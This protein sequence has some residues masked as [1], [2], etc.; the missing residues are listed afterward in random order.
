M[1]SLTEINTSNSAL[2]TED[3]YQSFISYLD[4]SKKTIDTYSRALKQ[5]FRYLSSKSIQQPNR[6][7]IIAFREELK[8]DHK[9]T[10]VQSY[11][12]AVR[13][14][15]SWTEIEGIYPN[16][17]NHVKGAKIS[18]EHKKDYLTANQVKL[19]LQSVDTS[20]SQGK[21]D[22]AILVLMFTCGLRTIEVTRANTG[23]LQSV[24]GQSVL[25]VQG[26]GKE[27][28]ADF[29]RLS[30]KTEQA[31]RQ[32]LATLSSVSASSPLFQSTS[33]NNIGGRLTTRAIS[34]IVK[35]Y[36][37]ANGFNSDRL[38]AHSTRHTAVTLALL[39]GET[40]QTVQQFARH[41]SIT[42]TQIYAHNLEAVSNNCCN[43]IA[44]SIF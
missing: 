20:T 40:L 5:F 21:R 12:V 38:T 7:D 24:G 42:T 8:A 25:L 41:S 32:Y 44:N 35:S 18:K 33:N 6:N 26:K 13:R 28:K 30:A 11:I 4:A 43:V 9:A 19:I 15:F 29:V 39:G 16:V 27:D 14:F 17:A 10:T 3:L 37:V 22:Y 36:L 23:D 34:G 1:T 31:I 2:I